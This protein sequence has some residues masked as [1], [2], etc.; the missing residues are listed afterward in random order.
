MRLF[1]S[2]AVQGLDEA[3][4][5]VLC[6]LLPCRHHPGPLLAVRVG[7]ISRAADPRLARFRLHFGMVQHVRVRVLALDRKADDNQHNQESSVRW[8]CRR[9]WCKGRPKTPRVIDLSDLFNVDGYLH[10]LCAL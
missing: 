4:G 6:R 2:K 3:G 1:D 10:G 7:W 5:C 8:E 9:L